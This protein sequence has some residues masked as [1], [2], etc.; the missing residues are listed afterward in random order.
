MNASLPHTHPWGVLTPPGH[1]SFRDSLISVETPVP[2]LDGV[3]CETW[4]AELTSTLRRR[5]EPVFS[6]FNCTALDIFNTGIVLSGP[7][8]FC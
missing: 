4:Q 8:F 7:F 5:Q 1:E 3:S 6:V 2:P